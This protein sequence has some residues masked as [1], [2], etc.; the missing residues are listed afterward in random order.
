MS[1]NTEKPRLKRGTVRADGRLFWCYSGKYE[2][3]LTADQ[4][5]K[6]KQM[7]RDVEARQREQRKRIEPPKLTKLE[8]II[9][10]ALN[11]GEPHQVLAVITKGREAAL[12][13][14][15]KLVAELPAEDRAAILPPVDK[16]GAPCDI[17]LAAP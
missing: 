7:T 4:F 5:E 3:W 6:Y 17:D 8:A 2:K 14:V 15:R 12:A 1:D 10:W 13:K 11:N 16:P 9:R